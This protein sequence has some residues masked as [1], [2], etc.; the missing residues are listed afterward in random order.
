VKTLK[1]LVWVALLVLVGLVVLVWFLFFRADA[2]AAVSVD[3]A[4]QQLTEDLAADPQAAPAAFDG[5]IDGV[6]VV[7]DQI[8]TFDFDT[9]SGS[10]AGFRVDE[11]LTVGSVVAV[12]RSGE[13]TGSLTIADGQL[14]ATEVTVDMTTIVSNDSRR[15]GA[16]SG[17][18]GANQFPT[19][20]FVLTEPVA[21]PAGLADGTAVSV[22]A[23]G[24]LTV[25]GVTRSLTFTI[26]ALIRDDG[27]GVVTGTAPIVFD[28][29]G[30][31]APKAPIVVSVDDTGIVEFQLI[32]AQP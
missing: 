20:T 21:L 8:G 6:W 24:D 26:E 1:R 32:V 29:F 2:P 17:A 31:S 25:K 10:F 5:L 22:Q 27:L 15:E 4:N 19:A 12:G 3:D 18:V 28:D 11:E 16:I 7:D 14:T 30:V 13:V 9:A 23:V